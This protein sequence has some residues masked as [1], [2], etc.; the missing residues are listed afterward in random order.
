MS[1]KAAT[2]E[3]MYRVRPIGR[4]RKTKKSATLEIFEP[5][6]PA[7]LQLE[8]FS[9]AVVVW[10]AD[11]RDSEKYRSRLQTKPPYARNKLTGV[12]ACRAEYRPNPVA[13][14]TC[15]I[16]GVDEG[17]GVVRVAWIDA[18][19][20]TPLVDLKPYFPVCDRV[21]EAH[22]PGWLPDWLRSEW[23]HNG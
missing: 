15:R 10:W 4:V 18:V 17:K 21:S 20:G 23:M 7:L 1:K 9:H 11:R 22:V 12:F 13:L 16:L 2:P 14:T 6:R 3:K 19:D 5:Y 8:H